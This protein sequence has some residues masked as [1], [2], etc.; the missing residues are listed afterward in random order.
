M[1]QT[2]FKFLPNDLGLLALVLA[3]LGAGLGVALWLCG[4]K[5]SRKLVTLLTVTLGML[6]GLQLP[7]WFGWGLDAWAASVLAAIV[8]GVTGYAWHKAWIGTGLGLVL[9]CWAAVMTCAVCGIGP[10][11]AAPNGVSTKLWMMTIWNSMSPS[12]RQHLPFTCL[13]AL[14]TGIGSSVLWPRLGT[15]LLYSSLGVSLLVS[16]GTSAVLSTKKD[17]LRVVPDQMSSQMVVL[18]ALVAFGAIF[19]WRVVPA[20]VGD[21]PWAK[22]DDKA[23]QQEQEHKKH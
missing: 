13:A 22:K 17:W 1:I 4:S 5:Y 6:V 10:I 18:L 9:A 15:V 21:D 11:P 3:I 16:L 2:L 7:G 8:F 20:K 14:L 23:G 12:S 19:Q